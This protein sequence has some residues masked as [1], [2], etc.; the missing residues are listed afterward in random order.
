MRLM[1]CVLMWCLQM[2]TLTTPAA[3]GPTLA[4]TLLRPMGQ[5]LW[6]KVKGAWG[7]VKG[8]LPF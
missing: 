3:P 4:S 5:S 1:L 7:L 6:G 2:A 8:V